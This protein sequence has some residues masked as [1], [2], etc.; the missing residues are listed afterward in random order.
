M[1]LEDSEFWDQARRAQDRLVDQYLDHPEV[2]LI[3][4]GYEVDPQ[5]Q[6]TSDRIVLR[7]H[8][9]LPSSREVLNL[10]TE[11]EGIPVRIVIANYKLE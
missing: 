3:D 4:I 5:G 7:V 6:K 11:V 1:P 2:S 8:V 9:R 10:P